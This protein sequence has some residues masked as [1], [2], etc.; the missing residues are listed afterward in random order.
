[1][2]IILVN[3]ALTFTVFQQTD[4]NDQNQHAFSSP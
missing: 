4:L 3:N 1:M 2:D